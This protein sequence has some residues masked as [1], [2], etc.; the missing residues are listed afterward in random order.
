M[1]AC[2]CHCA[3]VY[4]G[5]VSTCLYARNYVA[6]VCYGTCSYE[7]AACDSPI[8]RLVFIILIIL[9]KLTSFYSLQIAI[10]QPIRIDDVVI[11]DGEWGRVEEIHATYAVCEFVLFIDV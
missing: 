9:K 7:S 8:Y 6:H 1:R 2:F 4:V 5:V 3:P 11:V 10:A